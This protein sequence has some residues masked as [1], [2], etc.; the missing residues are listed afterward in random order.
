MP[1][2]FNLEKYHNNYEVYIETGFFEGGSVQTALDLDFREVHSCDINSQFIIKGTKK[3]QQQIEQNRLFLYLQK[4]TDALKEI[5][6]GLNEPAVF[7]LDAHDLKYVGTYDHEFSIEDG[8]PIHEELKIIGDHHIKEH[9]IIVDDLRMFGYQ[10]KPNTWAFNS[11]ATL[12]TIVNKIRQIN[13]DYKFD[14]EEGVLQH[15]Q[16]AGKTMWR[17]VLIA[18]LPK[19]ETK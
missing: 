14:L 3:F 5:L 4:S 17:D 1:I 2:N 16:I 7:F 13:P 18:Y 6:K 8:C 11:G 10:K 15:V 9:T 12:R 19:E